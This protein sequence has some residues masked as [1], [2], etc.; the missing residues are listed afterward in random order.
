MQTELTAPA[1]IEGH[2]PQKSLFRNRNFMLLTSGQ[3]ISNLGDFV[4]STTLL[5]WVF[6]LTN[7][8]SAVSNV[9]LAQ[10]IPI[11]LLGPI[12]GVFV[13]RWNRR[14][15]MVV[16][17]MIRV[18]AALLPL[19]V[20]AFLRLP[21]I[22]LSVFLIASFGRFF[23]PA[24]SGV[25]QV[26]VPEE[27]QPQAAS[28]SQATFAL[29]F[30]IGP[31]IAS[32]LYY[33]VGPTVALLI[34][35]ASYLVSALCL[36][37]LR[38]AREDLHPYAYKPETQTRVGFIPVLRELWA[39]LKFVLTTRIL[40]MI[41]LMCLIAML[42]AGALNALDIV[43][44]S[45]N[46]HSSPASYGTMT[47]IVGLG[48]LAGTL[49]AGIIAKWVKPGHILGGSVFLL[50]VG[51]IIYAFQ[52]VFLIAAIIAF[53]MCIPQGGIEVGFGPLMIK[54]TPREMMGRTQSFIDT[55]ISGVSLVSIGVAGAL[56]QF[57]PVNIILAVCGVLFTLAGLFGWFSLTEKST[58]AAAE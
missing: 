20:P 53:F 4:Y 31:A 43:F 18:G 23:M 42:G 11:F 57:I 19:V 52:S 8:A 36:L 30:I 54:A 35:S 46:L 41:T 5:V 58:P 38:V 25:L 49:I 37:G 14:H 12:A 27:Q 10:Y 28:I 15:T 1:T 34:N 56:A 45:K 24:K 21:T 6:S 51:I 29:S 55:S 17:D 33:A 2:P 3:A 44:V 48:T 40:L 9:L 13:D 32:P 7:S 50:G 39:G 22:L 47:A 26:I 16:A